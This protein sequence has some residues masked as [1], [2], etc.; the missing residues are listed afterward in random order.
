MKICTKCKIEKLLEEFYKDISSQD[1]LDYYCRKCQSLRDLVY[2]KKMRE[3]W[4]DRNPYKEKSEKRCPSCKE[5]FPS[6]YFSTDPG[7][8]DGLHN[9]CKKCDRRFEKPW[10]AASLG[11]VYVLE[12][13]GTEFYKIGKSQESSFKARMATLGGGNPRKLTVLY[14]A[15]VKDPYAVE[16]NLHNKY[17]KYN[18]NGEWFKLTSEIVEEIITY[19]QTQEISNSNQPQA[20][21]PPK[22]GFH[23][24]PVYPTS[25]SPIAYL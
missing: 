19:L 14:S 13:E 16:S 4:R 3:Y 7:K 2:R 15:L 18:G 9:R 12:E 6:A 25:S 20:P 8:K 1:G 21:K 5:I 10:L 23:Q 22:N 24:P 17:S 11:I